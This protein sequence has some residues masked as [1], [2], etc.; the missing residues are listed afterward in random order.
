MQKRVFDSLRLVDISQVA[1][2][3][4]EWRNQE[5]MGWGKMVSGCKIASVRWLEGREN[6]KN[7]TLKSYIRQGLPKLGVGIEK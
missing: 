1:D 5:R 3:V 6:R 7:F 2:G 4:G